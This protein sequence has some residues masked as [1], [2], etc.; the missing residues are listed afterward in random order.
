MC[1][2]PFPLEFKIH[3]YFKK[4]VQVSEAF[5]LKSWCVCVCGWGVGDVRG[6]VE[7]LFNV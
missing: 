6:V 2:R 4:S 1:F 7:E 3:L 5:I